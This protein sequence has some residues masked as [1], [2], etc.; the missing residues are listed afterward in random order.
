[1]SG[2]ISENTLNMLYDDNYNSSQ[3]SDYEPETTVC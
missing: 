3:D 2:I 1:M